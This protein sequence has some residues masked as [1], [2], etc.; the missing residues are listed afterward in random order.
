MAT[1]AGIE[2]AL[3]EA[4]DAISYVPRLDRDG[5]GVGLRGPTLSATYESLAAKHAQ[6]CSFL[7]CLVA[8]IQPSPH[9][10]PLRQIRQHSAGAC[11][12]DMG[13]GAFTGL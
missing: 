6:H 11:A 8:L 10:C 4:T 2:S 1:R 7:H 5:D 3:V 12:G 13:S 9:G